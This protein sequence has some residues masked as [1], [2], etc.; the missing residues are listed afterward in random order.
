LAGHGQVCFVTG[1]AGAGKTALVTEFARRAQDAHDDLIVAVG[2]CNAQTG[3][4]DPYLP[5]REVL[6]MLTG[7]VEGRL[8][9][10]AATQENAGRLQNF[11]RVSGQVLVDLGPD[12]IDIVVPGVGVATRAGAL[13]AGKVGW[14]D[15]L[16]EL[17]ERQAV[18][19]GVPG[20]E[21]SRI[22]EQHADVLGALAA[23]QPLLLV[24]DDLQWADAS[25]ISLLFHLGRRIEQSRI[26]I[27][28][29]YRSD[30]VAL[31]RGGERH[32]LEPVLN[33]LQRYFG[34]VWVN[35][36]QAEAAEGRQ[37]V[38]ALLDTDPNRLGE[39][40]RQ[41]LFEH[42]GGHP[43]FTVDLLRDLQERGDLIQDEVGRWV[44]GPSLNLGKLPARVEG[45]IA[46]RIGRLEDEL[47]EALTVASVE[48]E[49]FTAQVI[50]RVQALSERELVRRLTQELGRQHRLVQEQ[51]IQRVG[52]QR[53]SL[54]RFRHN[55]F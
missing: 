29:A 46:E 14:L 3:I 9:Q 20:L 23:K 45:V 54:Y 44:E 40:F 25:S 16:H 7:D 15:R 39:G 32:P 1:E 13:L 19:A 4:G 37:F 31:G 24:L 11:L 38:D 2:E 17:S 47:R 8:A 18:R 10:G 51:G 5:F 55:L 6:A 30:D 33:E 50:A 21:Q 27:V 42:T 52:G 22:F 26:L 43:L 35:L 49:D 12:L 41:A 34:D 53:L 36:E 48:G 28:G